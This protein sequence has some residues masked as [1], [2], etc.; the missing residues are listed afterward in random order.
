[1]IGTVFNLLGR[2]YK[3]YFF[4]TVFNEMLFFEDLDGNIRPEKTKLVWK[5]LAVKNKFSTNS[6]TKNGNF[7]SNSFRESFQRNQI[8]NLVT[9]LCVLPFIMSISW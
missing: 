3:N 5:I 8:P 2:K 9:A 1:M 4:Q 6:E 7:K